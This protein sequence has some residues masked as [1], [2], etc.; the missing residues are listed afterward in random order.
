M[1]VLKS[2]NLKYLSTILQNTDNPV[3]ELFL[4]ISAVIKCSYEKVFFQKEISLT[5]EEFSLLISFIKRRCDMEPLSK[6]I[7]SKE[8]YGIKFYTDKYTLDPR[9][10]TEL[11]IDLVR[12]YFVDVNKKMKILDLGCGTGCIGLSILKLYKNSTADLVDIDEN[13]INTAKMNADNLSLSDRVCFIKSDWFENINKKYEIIVSNP[14]Y[15]AEDFLLDDEVLYDP[16][17][18]L[19]AGKEGMDAYEKILPN[20][21]N[22]LNDGGM[23]FIEF[24]FGQKEKLL[25]LCSEEEILD[26]VEDF[27]MIPRV[28][29]LRKIPA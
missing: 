5:E 4:L 6:I 27:S 18:A 1:I 19:F 26:V 28:L 20:I 29:V 12:K 17:K 3:K 14:P 23:A 16:K 8:F 25:K 13:T 11:I 21:K 9:P 15:I 10:E 24:G 7:G 22:F 2:N